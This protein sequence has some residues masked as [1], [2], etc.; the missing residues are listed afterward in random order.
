MISIKTRLLLLLLIA[1]LTGTIAYG[2]L[3]SSGWG[4]YGKRDTQ[5][6]SFQVPFKIEVK[7]TYA[8]GKV[9]LEGSTRIKDSNLTR[10]FKQQKQENR[11]GFSS[12]TDDSE[13]SNSDSFY[14]GD[15]V[16]LLDGHFKLLRLTPIAG[17]SKTTVEIYFGLDQ[18]I[19]ALEAI[20]VRLNP[21]KKTRFEVVLSSLSEVDFRNVKA[22]VTLET[23]VAE[24]SVN[25]EFTAE[26][27]GHLVLGDSSMIDD[28]DDPSEP[29]SGSGDG[30]TF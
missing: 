11:S 20:E 17:T 4:N 28:F 15:Y 21:F 23:G 14:T 1:V 13:F 2:E 3:S 5:G 16:G 26:L 22:V 18:Q 19:P 30:L 9:V 6:E 25:K 27:S 24:E 12:D 8:D 10:Y 29:M 7:G